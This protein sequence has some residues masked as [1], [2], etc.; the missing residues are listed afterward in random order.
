MSNCLDQLGGRFPRLTKS[1]MSTASPR[2]IGD[3]EREEV[4]WC[5]KSGCGARTTPNGALN[6]TS[7]HRRSL[8]RGG[9]CRSTLDKLSLPS[10]FEPCR[11]SSICGR[12][13]ASVHLSPF[14]LLIRTYWVWPRYKFIGDLLIQPVLSNRK[15]PIANTTSNG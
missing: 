2:T 9:S 14:S 7:V 13:V 3:T 1:N 12:S 6:I 5:T 15:C 8:G 11:S 10:N 4:T